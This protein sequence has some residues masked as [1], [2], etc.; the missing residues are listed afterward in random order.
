MEDK[1]ITA[2]F[3]ILIWIITISLSWYWFNYKLPII[4]FL[5][6]WANNIERKLI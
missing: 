4:L 3:A 5:L 1:K 2:T 6:S